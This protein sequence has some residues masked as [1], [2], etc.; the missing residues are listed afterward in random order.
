M[1]QATI[2]FARRACSGGH[3]RGRPRRAC[4]PRCVGGEERKESTRRAL[5][6][7]QLL[8]LGLGYLDS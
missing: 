4:L 6:L 5:A 2:A 1:S 7:V 3:G 8:E